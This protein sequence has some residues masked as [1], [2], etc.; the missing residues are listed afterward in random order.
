[1][2]VTRGEGVKKSEDFA[3]VIY[4]SPLGRQELEGGGKSALGAGTASKQVMQA[5]R[6]KRI[7]A[8]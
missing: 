3:D 1:M 7:S 2:T 5:V 8:A 6:A 4:G